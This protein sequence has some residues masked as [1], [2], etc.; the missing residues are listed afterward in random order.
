MNAALI[1]AYKRLDCLPG[2]VDSLSKGG[3]KKIYAAID[4]PKIEEVGNDLVERVLVQECARYGIQLLVWKRSSNLGLA[5]SVI[6]GAD[7]F[8]SLENEGI[9]VED[10]LVFSPDFVR[11]AK[12]SL[13]VMNLHPDV[14]MVSG[15]QFS[16]QFRDNNVATTTNYPI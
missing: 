8:F 11:F 1:I 14:L 5:A 10:D 4:G 2:I 13:E 3:I 16:D 15:N 7:W 12:L 9:I 6:S